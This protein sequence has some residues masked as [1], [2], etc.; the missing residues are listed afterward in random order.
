[1]TT[2][3]SPAWMKA[4]MDLRKDIILMCHDMAQHPK[5]APTLHAVKAMASWIGQ[6]SQ[7]RDHI[8]SCADCLEERKA[9]AEIGAGIVSAGRGDV[10]QMDHYVLSKDEAALAGVPVVLTICDVATRATEFEAADTQ[11]AGETAR[12]IFTRWIRYQILS[13]DDHHGW[14]STFRGR[15]SEVSAEADGHSCT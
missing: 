15:S 6:R 5:M 8:D 13:E 10:I 2:E 1:M 12:L 7:V 4:E 14:S 3:K 9:V 11:T